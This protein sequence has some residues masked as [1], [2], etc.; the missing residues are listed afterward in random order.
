MEITLDED[1]LSHAGSN[2]GSQRKDGWIWLYKNKIMHAQN[3]I[4]RSQK[5]KDKLR[6]RNLQRISQRADPS[7]VKRIPNQEKDT[8]P[9]RKMSKGHEHWVHK[10]EM[11]MVRYLFCSKRCKLK[12]HWGEPF[13]TTQI[14]RKSILLLKLSIGKVVGRHVVSAVAGGV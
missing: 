6:K 1:G 4:K 9:D 7:N 8:Y 3:S 13:L 10:K 14:W 12:W 5:A 2:S 11:Q